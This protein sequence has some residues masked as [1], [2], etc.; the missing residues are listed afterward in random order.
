MT[1]TTHAIIL[2]A[3]FGSRLKA[4]EG[5]KLLATI[6]GRTL[7]S[8]HLD[9]FSR[10]GIT[11]LTIVTG[12]EHEALEAA[13]ARATAAQ[14]I[15]VHT[16]YNQDFDRSNGLSVLAGIEQ[17]GAPSTIPFWL[18]MGDHLFDPGLFSAIAS[19][20][21]TAPTGQGALYIDRKLDTIYDVP[22]ATKLRFE[23]DGNL[24]AIGKEIGEFNAV[25]VGLFWCAPGFVTALEEA[26]EESGDCSTSDAVRALEAA[27]EFSFPE[28]GPYLW[29][30]VDT[31]GA[32]THAEAL[33]ASFA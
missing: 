16:A 28:I 31:P 20:E 27:G 25:D 23:Q 32:R 15:R 18:T 26:L 9:A 29:Q 30:D 3:G 11:D 6:D 19:G 12:F 17:S 33:V 13:V 8:W 1:E 14:P 7:L 2:A 4:A 10:L 22:D 24:D 5:H 21:V